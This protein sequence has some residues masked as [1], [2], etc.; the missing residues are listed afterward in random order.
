MINAKKAY[1]NYI[2][3]KY[4]SQTEKFVHSVLEQVITE[5]RIYRR[6]MYAKT[7]DFDIDELLHKVFLYDEKKYGEHFITGWVADYSDLPIELEGKRIREL[8]EELQQ[9]YYTKPESCFICNS[10]KLLIRELEIVREFKVK[11]DLQRHTLTISW[12]L[13]SFENVE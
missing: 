11:L 5:E 7:M 1:G 4:Y 8:V 3:W 9:M 13:P 6:S 2:R 10:F 12:D